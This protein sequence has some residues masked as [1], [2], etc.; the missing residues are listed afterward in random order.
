[1]PDLLREMSLKKPT[2]CTRRLGYYP[3]RIIAVH[4]YE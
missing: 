1:M 3:E 4:G 2:L